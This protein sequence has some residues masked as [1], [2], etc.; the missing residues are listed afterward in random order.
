[1]SAEAARDRTRPA[2]RLPFERSMRLRFI[3]AVL[4]LIGLAA[5]ESSGTRGGYVGGGAGGNRLSN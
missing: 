1:G 3:L 4:L 2:Q 5:C